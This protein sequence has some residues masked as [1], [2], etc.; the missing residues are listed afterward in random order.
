VQDVLS[1]QVPRRVVDTA[2]GLPHIKAGK[3]VPPGALARR[4]LATL[5]EQGVGETEVYARPGPPA[6]CAAKPIAGTR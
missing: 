2:I 5:Q 1:N 6:T 3:L 4:R